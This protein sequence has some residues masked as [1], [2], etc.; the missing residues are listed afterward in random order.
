VLVTLAA[1][2]LTAIA[3]ALG[4]GQLDPPVAPGPGLVPGRTAVPAVEAPGGATETGLSRNPFEYGALAPAPVAP[5]AASGGYRLA[6]LPAPAPTPAVRLVG[7]V[8]KAGKVRVALMVRDEMVLLE[9]GEEE[10]G[11]KLLALEEDVGV[12]LRDP[13]GVEFALRFEP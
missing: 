9:V 4:R 13:Q 5:P 3:L 11:F 6:E 2:G 1:L 12:R 10:A 7:L 8:Q